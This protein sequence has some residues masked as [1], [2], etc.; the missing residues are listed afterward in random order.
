MFLV[1]CLVGWSFASALLSKVEAPAANS[2]VL[3][4]EAGVNGKRASKNSWVL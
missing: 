2:S 4:V 1:G 3:E